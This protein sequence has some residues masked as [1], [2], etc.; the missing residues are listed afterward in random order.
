M[1]A[2]RYL[3]HVEGNGGWADR[4]Y[5]LLLSPQLVLAQDLPAR[6][7]YEQLLAPGVTHLAVDS[8]FGNLSAVVRWA[9]AHPAEVAVMVA[10]ANRAAELAT[11]LRGARAYV[12]ELLQRYASLQQRRVRSHRTPL[13][14]SRSRPLRTVLAWDGSESR[15]VATSWF[16][17]AAALADAFFLVARRRF[18]ARERGMVELDLS[19]RGNPHRIVLPH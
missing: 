11:S 2:F 3:V 5:Q 16:G 12:S 1:A 15:S 6:L 13:R 9:R 10:R 19:G 8:N 4:L 18:E 14:Q 17:A 7:W